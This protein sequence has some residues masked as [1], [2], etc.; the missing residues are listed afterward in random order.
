MVWLEDQKI[1]L[2][3][4][5]DRKGLRNTASKDWPNTF[6]KVW[7]IRELVERNSRNKK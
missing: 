7:K 6:K 2:Y 3:K 4:I 5:E 1:R